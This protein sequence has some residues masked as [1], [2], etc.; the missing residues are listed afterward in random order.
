M[1]VRE[2]RG[3]KRGQGREGRREGGMEGGREVGRDTFKAT[4]TMSNS[5]SIGYDCLEKMRW[6]LKK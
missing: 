1:R 2:T 5:L 4:C 3:G 6:V